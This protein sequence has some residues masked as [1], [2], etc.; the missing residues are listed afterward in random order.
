MNKKE[1]AITIRMPV[2][3]KNKAVDDANKRDMSLSMWVRKLIK[4]AK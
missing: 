3:I 4:R 2:D 1:V